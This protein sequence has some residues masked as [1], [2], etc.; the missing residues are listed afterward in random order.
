MACI[1]RGVC[2]DIC[3]KPIEDEKAGWTAEANGCSK[4]FCA[5]CGS[6]VQQYVLRMYNGQGEVVKSVMDFSPDALL[7][8]RCI[9]VPE[10]VVRIVLDVAL[11]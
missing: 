11:P 8:A 9:D 5:D 4:Y 7:S 6:K 3:S 2:C 10:D 1:W